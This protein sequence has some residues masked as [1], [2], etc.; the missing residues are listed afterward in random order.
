MS[1]LLLLPEILPFLSA[2]ERPEVRANALKILL[3]D[4]SLTPGIDSNELAKIIQAVSTCLNCPPLVELAL[5]LFVNISAE[6]IEGFISE[7]PT[8]LSAHCLRLAKAEE[9]V[10]LLMM[11]L[12]NLSADQS[13][14]NSLLSTPNEEDSF[15]N[16][17]VQRFIAYNPQVEPTDTGEISWGD[18]DPW[19]HAGS[20]VCNLSQLPEGRALL[21]KRSKNIISPLCAQIGSRNVLRRRGAV[22][23][24]RNC[25]FDADEH[26]W[27]VQEQ[28]IL[29]SLLG[30][31]VVTTPFTE[32]EKIGMDPK[33]W[34]MVRLCFP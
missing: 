32:E 12:S 22:A 26:W 23:S 10:D 3:A 30:P 33:L 2:E 7:F 1:A 8:N 19:Q 4:D 20:I 15:A 28:K 29:G 31:L 13:V 14:S 9:S 16:L 27:L 25:L 21:C 24:V 11:F 34:M 18:T 6:S 17:I 5:T